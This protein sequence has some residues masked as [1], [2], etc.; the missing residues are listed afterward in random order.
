MSVN[1]DRRRLNIGISV[2]FIVPGNSGGLDV[3]CRQLVE[4]LANCETSHVFTILCLENDF[5][6]WQ[7]RA[8][9]AHI[10]FVAI[11]DCEPLRVLPVR[12]KRQAQRLF[13]LP[14][15]PTKGEAYIS[16]QIDALNLDLIHFPATC[17][18]PLTV[19]TP[20]VLG[21]ADM[22]HEYYPEFYTTSEL[23][24]R[25][26]KC[27]FSA[28][29]AIRIIAPSIYTRNTLIEKY[30]ID[31]VK[32]TVIPYGISPVGARPLPEDITRVRT[33]Y[34]LPP[35]Y[36]YYPANPWPHKNHARLMA[37]LRLYTQS[38]G[39]PPHLVVSGR[40]R[41]EVR[42]VAELALAAGVTGL[43]TDIGFVPFEDV[44]PL[45]C[46][47]TMLVFPSLFEG[48]GIP[49]IEAMALGCP[50]AAA[51]ATAIPECVG[52][53]ALLFD[54]F[55]VRAIAAAIHQLTNDEL[56]RHALTARGYDQMKRYAWADIVA[57]TLK[58][59]EAVDTG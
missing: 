15:P 22:Q 40:L 52:P 47:A 12:L 20:C 14:L 17:I 54:P 26:R 31:A 46:G 7:Y 32:I 38:Y 44:A 18:Y 39:N 48:F 37:A 50:I 19:Q 30:G 57:K 21:F 59:Y 5:S 27:R 13:G 43:V 28:G 11:S 1:E 41:N 42:S 10:K 53:A 35:S 23:E 16:W 8:W 9:P 55:D 33:K 4:A 51:N 29:K 3:F 34:G 45:Y 49:L 24:S 2:V 6:V 25:T 56:L 36:M 58:V